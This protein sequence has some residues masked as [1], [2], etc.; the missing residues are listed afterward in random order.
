MVRGVYIDR[1]PAERMKLGDAMSRYLTEITPTKGK[2]AATREKI[3]AKPIL[4]KLGRFSLAA[5]TPQLIAEYRDYRLSTP[6]AK[7]GKLLSGNTVRLELALI[8]HLFTVAIQEWGIGLPQNP[9]SM[10]RKPKKPRPRDQRITQNEEKRLLEECGK[11]S[12][13]MLFWIVVLA[14]ET[15]MRKSEILSLTCGQVDLNKRVLHLPETK[16]GTSRNVPLTRRAV[17]IF[18]EAINHPVR[19]SDTDLIFWGE[20]VWQGTGQ[21]KPYDFSEAWEKA[22]DEAGLS[23]LHFHDLRH[24]AVS[25]LVESGFGDQEVAAISGHK[26]M[27]MLKR[28]THLRAKDLVF[29]LDRLL[30]TPS[31]YKK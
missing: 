13:P 29:K 9:V 11:H 7:T 18:L 21:R 19:P 23:K 1:L 27:Q 15:G 2:G 30:T 16:N 22:R 25:R 6:S 28:Y 3:T 26:S 31:Q 24:E 12:N 14:L 4:E 20:A 17:Q 10:I 8:S 5:I